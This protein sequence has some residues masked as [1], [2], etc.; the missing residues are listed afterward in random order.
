M[1]SHAGTPK[2]A[3]SQKEI[4]HF[5]RGSSLVALG[6]VIKIFLSFATEITAAHILQPERYGLITWG[7]FIVNIVCMLTTFGLNT[8]MRRFIPIYHAKSDGGS[9]HGIIRIGG[10][11][12]L[13]GGMLGSLLLIIGANWLAGSVL[14]DKREQLVLLTF[15]LAVPFWNLQKV[16]LAI[17][18]G[19]ERPFYKV[20]IEDIL[21]SAGFL[22]VVI[23][24][25]VLDFKEIGIARGY[26]LVFC[27][28]AFVSLFFVRTK[29]PLKEIRKLRPSYHL[30]TLLKFSL[31]L[32]LTEPLGKSTG[33]IDVLIVGAITTSYHVG[34]F[35]VA[36]DLASSMALVLMCLGYMYLPIISRFISQN[37]TES[38]H[39][40][41]VRTTRW[42]MLLTFPLFATFFFFPEDIIHLFYGPQYLEA[43]PVLRILAIGY[44]GHAMV[45]F[46]GINLAAAGMTGILM[47]TS[48]MS[49]IIN[50]S[51]NY[52]LIPLFG[53]KGAAFASLTSLWMVNAIYLIVMKKKMNLQP[54]NKMYLQSFAILFLLATIC[55]MLVKTLKL[56]IGTTAPSAAFVGFFWLLCIGGSCFFLKK[57]YFIDQIDMELLR[58]TLKK[59]SPALKS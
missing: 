37:D 36:S 31:P 46:T 23:T 25:W 13:S 33:L 2:D 55:S 45:G 52:I 7:L 4:T 1:Y 17:F 54:F 57:G 12:S 8:A 3:D 26:V 27:I 49:F 28:S 22:A 35:R 6:M 5:F 14:G 29:T 32:T 38:W 34:V 30:P 15:V 41:N 19:F 24:A 42:S 16:L 51:G 59:I 43:S 50:L 39:E 56:V 40:M 9:L 44:F 58:S 20:I 48:I 18:G 10:I 21:T 11:L 53:I 47:S